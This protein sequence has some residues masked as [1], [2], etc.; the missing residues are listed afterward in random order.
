[1]KRK[2]NWVT[3]SSSVKD[4]RNWSPKNWLNLRVCF[5]SLQHLQGLSQI[6]HSR[7][8]CEKSDDLIEL[9]IVKQ[10]QAQIAFSA[11]MTSDQVTKFSLEGKAL[12]LLS[13][14]DIKEHA[15]RIQEIDSLEQIILCGNTIGVDAS[16]DLA[17]ALK[18]H[19]KL[20]VILDKITQLLLRKSFSVTF[21]QEDF[22]V[23][24]P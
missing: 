24:F 17:D 13:S 3:C 16:K 8:R 19:K 7:G 4:R 22:E 5:Y 23:K 20:K 9:N 2:I 21:S 18:K 12:K 14:S 11:T 1:M 15:E 6:S 10:K